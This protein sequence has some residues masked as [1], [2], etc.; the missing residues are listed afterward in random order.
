MVGV[1]SVGGPSFFNGIDGDISVGNW[2]LMFNIEDSD[3]ISS[4]VPIF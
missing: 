2:G 1:T 4:E 3:E